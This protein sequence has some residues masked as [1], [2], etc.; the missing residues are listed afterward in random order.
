MN[1]VLVAYTTMSGSTTEVAHVIGEEIISQGLHVDVLPLEKVSMLDA[2]HA[3]V[4]GAPMDM[5]WHRSA[6]PIL[7][8]AAPGRPVSIAFFGG[9]LDYQRLK[10]LPKLFVQLVIQAQP[11]DRRNWQAIRSWAAGLPELFYTSEFRIGED[12]YAYLGVNN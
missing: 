8:A 7:E 5:G 12:L 10:L 6:A 1:K 3:V 11:G 2:Y 4:L 9:H